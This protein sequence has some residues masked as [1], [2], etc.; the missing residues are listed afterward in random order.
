M[1]NRIER[2]IFFENQILGAADLTATVEYDRGQQARHNRYV[3][4]WGIAGGLELAGKD[5]ET[6]TGEKYQ[7]ITLSPGMA[8]DGTGREIVVPEAE[9][10]SEDLF[11]Q[12]NVAIADPDARYPVFLI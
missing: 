7:E 2:P 6:S 9:Q 12:R 10:L 1:S 11:D 8:I 5:K 3:H 4:L